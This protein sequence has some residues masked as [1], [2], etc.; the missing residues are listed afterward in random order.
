MGQKGRTD[1]VG[2]LEP[3][4]EVALSGS[5]TGAPALPFRIALGSQIIQEILQL[6][7]EETV[8][9]I[10]ENPYLQADKIYPSRENRKFCTEKNIRL[11]GPAH[12]RPLSADRVREVQKQTLLDERERVEVEGGLG[13]LKRRYSWDEIRARLVSTAI[14]WICMAAIAHNLGKAYWAFLSFVLSITKRLFFTSQIVFQ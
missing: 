5:E 3:L 8:E 14:T 9:Q 13:E 2:E 1:S 6:S 7:D 12:G 4:Y 11:S 10:C